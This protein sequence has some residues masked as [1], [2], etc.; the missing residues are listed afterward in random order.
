MVCECV[1]TLF[2]FFLGSCKAAA[3]QTPQSSEMA[4]DGTSVWGCRELFLCYQ[5]GLFCTGLLSGPAEPLFLSTP[6]GPDCSVQ[7]PEV[8]TALTPLLVPVTTKNDELHSFRKEEAEPPKEPTEQNMLT[9][10]F[11]TW[12][13]DHRYMSICHL[14]FIYL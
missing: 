9:F 8:L 4:T 14:I 1:H 7:L 11:Q 10:S 13:R 12:T 5:L 3:C 2:L 6:R